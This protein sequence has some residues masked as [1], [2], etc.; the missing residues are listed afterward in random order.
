V[1][2][3]LDRAFTAFHVTLGA[4][5]FVESVRTAIHAAHG[6]GHALFLLASL[7][8]IG[9]ALFLW[10]RTV[11]AGAAMMLWTFAIAFSVHAV[12]GDFHF[13]LLVFAAGTWLVL[14][15]R[16]GETMEPRRT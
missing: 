11:V 14:V 1:P 5:I 2:R 3:P 7:E 8:A 9:A 16:R 13:A 12:Q 15:R 4:V 10:S 6:G